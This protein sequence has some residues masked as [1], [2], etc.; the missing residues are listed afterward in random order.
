VI[1]E[2]FAVTAGSP[3][4]DVNSA[5]DEIRAGRMVVVIDDEDRENE[6]DLKMAS[7]KITLEAVSFIA[8]FGRGLICLAIAPERLDHLQLHPMTAQNTARFGTA[9]TESIDAKGRFG[10]ESN[11]CRSSIYRNSAPGA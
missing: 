1:K 2:V 8:K 10:N 6:G 4:T 11:R 7:Q 9:F 3:F 5:V